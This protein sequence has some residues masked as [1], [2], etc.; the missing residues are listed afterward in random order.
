MTAS[1]RELGA[2]ISCGYS[3][4]RVIHGGS[5][6][7]KLC[8]GNI[9]ALHATLGA[10]MVF[11]PTMSLRPE[12]L[13]TLRC[14]AD[15]AGC[16]QCAALCAGAGIDRRSV[17]HDTRVGEMIGRCADGKPAGL[18]TAVNKIHLIV[19]T[20]NRDPSGV[21]DCRRAFR[22]TTTAAKQLAVF[23]QVVVVSILAGRAQANAVD[24]TA[25]VCAVVCSDVHVR[26]GCCDIEHQTFVVLTLILV[27]KVGRN[28]IVYITALFAKVTADKVGNAVLF[29]GLS[30]LE[31]GSACIGMIV[32]G[33]HNVN[34]SLFRSRRNGFMEAFAAAFCVGV[35]GRLM[36]SKNLPRATTLCRILNQPCA[37][38]L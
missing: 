18:I 19:S 36:H 30:I 28:R 34:A 3:A 33:E 6:N 25:A 35:V 29:Y 12:S 22:M 31:H 27:A 8:L 23:V 26:V 21:M 17:M 7:C 15:I 37:S 4:S 2:V 24:D 11:I 32:A 1:E 10:D 9:L 14:A 16:D 5:I 38:L 13:T 20:L